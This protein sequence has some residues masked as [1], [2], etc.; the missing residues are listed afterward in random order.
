MRKNEYNALEYF[1]LEYSD[2]EISEIENHIGIDFN[3]KGTD[4]RMCRE[5]GW[6]VG[7]KC[8]HVVQIVSAHDKF[9]YPQPIEIGWY[10]SIE[11]VL[12]NCYIEGRQ[13]KEIIMDDNTEILGKD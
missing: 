1:R 5:P 3:Y 7:S 2:T 8:Y 6:P 11:D 9:Q 10:F 12:E 4:Y 13:F